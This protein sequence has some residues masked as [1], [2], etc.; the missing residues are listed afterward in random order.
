MVTYIVLP[1]SKL[2]G[3]AVSYKLKPLTVAILVVG[4]HKTSKL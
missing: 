3:K 2:Q 1:V 4:G